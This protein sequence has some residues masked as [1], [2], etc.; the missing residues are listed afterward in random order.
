MSGQKA[1]RERNKEAQG[2]QA[3][4]FFFSPLPTHQAI[5]TAVAQ[6]LPREVKTP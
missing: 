2:L 3:L 5:G 4:G 1:G 6:I